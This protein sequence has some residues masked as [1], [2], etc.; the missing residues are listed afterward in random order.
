MPHNKQ[1]HLVSSKRTV[2]IISIGIVVV[3]VLVA[4]L[5]FFI[6]PNGDCT[7]AMYE[8][9]LSGNAPLTVTITLTEQTCQ[10]GIEAPITFKLNT[11]MQFN[12]MQGEFVAGPNN[13]FYEQTA[14]SGPATT[15]TVTLPA[16]GNYYPVG[17][18]TDNGGRAANV[19]GGVIQVGSTST[20]TT[21]IHRI[22]TNFGSIDHFSQPE[23]N[24]RNIQFS[25]GIHSF[26][27]SRS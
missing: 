14:S 19:E 25:S 6:A 13:A 4:S 27:W 23:W 15:F 5:F 10:G 8:N 12:T 20:S 16:A 9:P 2:A 11:N 3:A 26:I 24:W 17:M 21:V 7:I 1:Y 22:D 18:S